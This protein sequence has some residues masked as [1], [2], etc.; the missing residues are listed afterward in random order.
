M[1]IWILILKDDGG[2]FAWPF[3]KKELAMAD[4]ACEGIIWIP[5][6]HNPEYFTGEPSSDGSHLVLYSVVVDAGSDGGG[7]KE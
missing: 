5:S 1:K 6:E 4:E 7:V 3:S 2:A